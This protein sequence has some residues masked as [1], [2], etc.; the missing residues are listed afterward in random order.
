MH[1]L[2]MFS[3]RY[4][5]EIVTEQIFPLKK[6]DTTT[7][8]K[9]YCTLSFFFNYK[10]LKHMSSFFCSSYRFRSFWRTIAKP[11]YLSKKWNWHRCIY[12]RKISSFPHW[13]VISFY[14]GEIEKT[15]NRFLTDIYNGKIWYFI[16]LEAQTLL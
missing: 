13:H 1:S 6:E 8:N 12:L 11:T 9:K 2:F 15:R 4:H 3:F 10:L 5:G 14:P 7:I 16:S